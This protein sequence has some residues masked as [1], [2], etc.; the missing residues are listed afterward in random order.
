MTYIIAEIGNNH[1]G[2][3]KR[4]LKLIKAASMSGANAVKL[5]S[6][7]GLDIIS[8]KVLSSFY[9]EW[10]SMGFEYWYQ[11]ADSIALPISDHQ[12]AIDYAHELNLEFVTTPVNPRI[13]ELLEKLNGI[14][15]YKVAS[16]DLNNFG[17][18]KAMSQT[19]KDIIISTGMGTLKEISK[20]LKILNKN[21]VS[22]LHCVSDYPLNP[23]DAFLNNIKILK[24]TFPNNL[25]GFSDHSLDHELAIASVIIGAEIIEK[26]FTINRKDPNAAEHH[27]SMEP[28][29]FL[30]MVDWI[31]TIKHNLE[32]KKWSRSLNELN[33]AKTISRRSFHYVKNFPKG[34]KINEKDI[35]VI[36]IISCN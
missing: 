18:L 13:T 23:K 31:K 10:N 26:H 20:A 14:D 6:F 2:S 35:K 36:L 8:P 32:N 24:E 25:I 11:Y 19:K 7:T 28:K 9:P 3:I 27:F 12:I 15:K 29:E 22:I 34:Y 33:E 1:N 16:M 17:L 21:N 4:C 30:K 5:Q